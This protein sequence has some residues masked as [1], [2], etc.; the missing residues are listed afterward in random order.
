MPVL[1]TPQ[2]HVGGA[3]QAGREIGMLFR[4]EEG[5][6]DQYYVIYDRGYA[7][8]PRYRPNWVPSWKGLGK[9]F[10]AMEDGQPSIVSTLF[11]RYQ[12]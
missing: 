4:N 6:R 8:R 5:W 12:F 9:D 1:T 11:S 3:G 2:I 7:L 10:F